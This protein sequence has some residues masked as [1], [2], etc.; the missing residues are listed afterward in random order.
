MPCSLYVCL[1]DDNRIAGFT[2]DPD[3]GRLALQA[4]TPVAGGPSVLALS[5]NR[6][7]LYVG[8]RG[9]PRISR[10]VIDPKSGGLTP[11][12]AVATSHAPTFLAPDRTGRFLLSA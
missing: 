9:E 6:R 12:G 3:S 7:V 2:L 10:F 1:Q 5:P 4:E 8:H 11:Q